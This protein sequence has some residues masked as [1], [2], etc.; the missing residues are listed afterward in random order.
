MPCGAVECTLP[1]VKW[2]TEALRRRFLQLFP[3]GTKVLCH[4]REK[5]QSGKWEVDLV[6]ENGQKISYLFRKDRISEEDE[7]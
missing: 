6:S 2:P 5:V 3:E 1:G 4:F 7:D